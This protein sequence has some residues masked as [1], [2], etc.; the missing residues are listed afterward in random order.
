MWGVLDVH[1]AQQAR[2]FSAEHNAEAQSKHLRQLYAL[3]LDEAALG[4]VPRI[5]SNAP[6]FTGVPRRVL[7]VVSS[8]LLAIGVSRPSSFL[9]REFRVDGHRASELPRACS[10]GC[11]PCPT[12]SPASCTRR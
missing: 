11:R 3:L 5:L 7:L 4:R 8:H 1:S 2:L 9:E 10:T 6:Y 12:S